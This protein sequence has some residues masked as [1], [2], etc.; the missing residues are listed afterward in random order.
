MSEAQR[1]AV[2]NLSRRRGI[3][4]DELQKMVMDAYG[5]ALEGLSAADASKFIR[6]LQMSA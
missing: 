3:S 1:R 2:Y 6:Q 4:V 5:V